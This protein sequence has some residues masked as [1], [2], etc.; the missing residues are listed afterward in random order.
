[1][2]ACAKKRRSKGKIRFEFYAA[3]LE[4]LPL[5]D[6]ATHLPTCPEYGAT[7][8]SS[9]RFAETLRLQCGHTPRR[10]RIALSKH[11]QGNALLWTRLCAIYTDTACRDHGHDSYL[12]FP[13]RTPQTTFTHVLH[14]RALRIRPKACAE[15]IRHLC[16][17][18]ILE[19]E[20]AQAE[21]SRHSR[22]TNGNHKR[23]VQTR[24]KLSVHDGSIVSRRS[25]IVCTTPPTLSVM[26]VPVWLPAKAPA[27][28]LTRKPWS[29]TSLALV[30]KLCP[31]YL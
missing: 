17:S 6:R 15:G 30:A 10:D 27:L 16:N 3:G 26:I 25:Q 24:C 4:P 11:M 28:W 8:G 2:N 9:R 19:G 12:R 5:A 21:L 31:P 1:L 18:E 13:A 20:G 23:V 22:G 29:K 14:T 7:C